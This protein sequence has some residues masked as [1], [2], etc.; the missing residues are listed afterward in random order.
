MEKSLS[1]RFEKWSAPATSA[2]V[3]KALVE[4]RGALVEL[5][6][7]M[8]EML[9]GNNDAAREHLKEY[10]THDEKLKNLVI[11]IGGLNLPGEA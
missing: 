9:G 1:P 7:A 3:A 11:E 4:T 2:E 5:N 6:N 8:V 10:R